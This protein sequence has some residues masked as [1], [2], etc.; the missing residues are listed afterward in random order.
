M[1]CTLIAPI[2]N[3]EVQ[4]GFCMIYM[5]GGKIKGIDFRDLNIT[6]EISENQE[7]CIHY[8]IVTL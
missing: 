5:I 2:Y 3:I 4:H 6:H 1:L 7:F 8:N